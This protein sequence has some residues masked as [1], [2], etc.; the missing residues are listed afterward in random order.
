[1]TNLGKKIILSLVAT[2]AISSS[3]NGADKVYAI[4]DGESVT[5][6]DIAMILRGQ[7]VT[8]ESL[9]E[10]QQKQ[11]IEGLVEQKLLSNEAYKSDITKSAEYKIELEK[12]KK[13]LAFQF[14]MR[15]FSKETKVTEKE[16][17]AFYN[18]NKSKMKSPVELK[19]SHIL[20]KTKSEADAI[21]KELSKSSNLKKDFTK[22]AQTKSTGPSGS[23]GGELGWFT[24]EKMV[25]EFSDAT[26]KLKKGE[27]TKTAVKTQFG[28]HIIYLDDKKEAS[29]I[30][31]DVVKARLQQ[32]LLQRNFTINVK[33]RAEELKKNA[34]IEYK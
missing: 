8:Y 27:I 25:P 22:L 14:W 4:V 29:A 3:V 16:L 10:V 12:F 33:K 34:K 6:Q 23:N 13:N 7:K 32:D 17:K 11:I 20:V 21:I 2:L 28:F 31:Y 15:D 30:A 26:L 19:A 1:M 18:E 24:K 9:P 5:D